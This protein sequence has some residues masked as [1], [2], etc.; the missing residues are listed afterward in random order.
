ME[1]RVRAGASEDGVA[2]GVRAT[3]DFPVNAIDLS[4]V[5]PIYN[6]AQTIDA[7]IERLVRV[8]GPRPQ[9]F[10]LIFVDDGS[11]DESLPILE[12]RAAADTRI[13]V[14]ALTRNFGG[15]A[16]L[17]AGF[18]L[19]RGAR[20]VCLDGDLENR[21]E[22]IPA[23]LAAL[24]GGSD[25]ACGVRMQR[26][27]A[28]WRRILSWLLNAY[29]RRRIGT[30]VRDI[31]CGMRAMDSRVIRNLAAEGDRRRLLT[32]LLLQ[33]ARAVTEVPIQHD[34]SA[35]PGGHSF[36]TLLG[37]A[38]DFYLST[39]RRPF[40]VAGLA[41]AA[42]LLIGIALLVIAGGW[43]RPSLAM[44]GLLLLATGVGGAEIALVGEYAQRVYYLMQRVPF[45]ELKQADAADGPEIGPGV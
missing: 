11:I 44:G 24:D 38:S 31:G 39:A 20:T 17:C 29:V 30:A 15:Q 37:I 5:V 27:A 26:H 25:L 34:R 14:A 43:R 4:V 33:R 1:S 23:L 2:W 32:P 21:P 36:L 12:R 18:D 16:A 40:L 3:D 8:L 41:S 10:E 22:D 6:N 9:S 35:R 19:V 42:S 28:W 7:L 45:Y 13:R